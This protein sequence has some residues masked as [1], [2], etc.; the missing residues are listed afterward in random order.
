[1]RPEFFALIAILLLLAFYFSGSR[2]QVNDAIYK[3]EEESNRR[4]RLEILR[5]ADES[6]K[7]DHPRLL[8]KLAQAAM[9][10]AYEEV[11]WV[12]RLTFS[13]EAKRAAMRAINACIQKGMNPQRDKLPHDLRSVCGAAEE[14]EA[15]ARRHISLK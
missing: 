8:L 6:L 7:Y 14:C 15:E 2:D 11:E 13:L 4:K 10:V 3:A 12:E 9:A 5:K 1:M